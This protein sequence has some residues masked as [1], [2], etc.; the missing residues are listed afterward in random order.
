MTNALEPSAVD[1]HKRA[2]RADRADTPKVREPSA[3]DLHKR[4]RRVP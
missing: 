1:A 3:H 2:D 4:T